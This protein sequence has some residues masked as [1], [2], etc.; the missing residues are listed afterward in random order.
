MIWTMVKVTALRLLRDRGALAMAFL[1]PPA[2]FVVFATIFQGTSGDQMRLSVAL[3]VSVSSETN[4]R[5]EEALRA[6]PSLRFQPETHS[7]EAAVRAQVQDGFADAGLFV[8]GDIAADADGP[9]VVLVDRGKATAGA[10]LAGRVQEAVAAA[11]PDIG[12]ARAAPLVERIVGGLTA[13]QTARLA[14][15]IAEM[16]RNPPDETDGGAIVAAETI[17]PAN[18]PGGIVTYY[19]GAVA[20]LSCCSRPCRVPP[21]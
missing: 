1:L 12:L 13:E 4:R 10:I 8:R 17:G 6:V 5:L 14:A 3:G 20:I 21:R 19:I 9:V 15:G 18:G 2:I 16:R 7:D 11:M